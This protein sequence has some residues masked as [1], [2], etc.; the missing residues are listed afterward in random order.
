LTHTVDRKQYGAKNGTLWYPGSA[1]S[2]SESHKLIALQ[3]TYGQH[4]HWLTLYSTVNNTKQ[5]KADKHK[6][7]FVL[8]ETG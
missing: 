7:S 2:Y 1:V 8:T 6:P 4:V 5:C 3:P